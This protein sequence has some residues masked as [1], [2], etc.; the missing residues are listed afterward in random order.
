[1]ALLRWGHAGGEHGVLLLRH[2][3][4][5]HVREH[6]G[7]VFLGRVFRPTS[8]SF[9]GVLFG[10]ATVNHYIISILPG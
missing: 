2:L 7:R 1:M 9:P 8:T 5:L 4:M 3:Q 10:S 6:V